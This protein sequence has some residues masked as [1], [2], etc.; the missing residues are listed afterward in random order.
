MPGSSCVDCAARDAHAS[1]RRPASVSSGLECRVRDE[2][3]QQMAAQGL[4]AVPTTSSGLDSS[5]YTACR[6]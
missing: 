1:T 4:G 2:R 3:A 6:L 5:A